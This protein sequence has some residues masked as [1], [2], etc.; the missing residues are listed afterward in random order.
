LSGKSGSDGDGGRL[1]FAPG[2]RRWLLEAECDGC[3]GYVLDLRVSD[4]EGR[5]AAEARA[6]AYLRNVHEPACPGCRSQER[7]RGGSS[8]QNGVEV[9]WDAPLGEWLGS[10]PLPGTG[11]AAWVPLG[12][13]TYWARRE[14]EAAA[15]MLL[16]SGVPLRVAAHRSEVDPDAFTVLYDPESGRWVLRAGCHRCGGFELRLL[17]AGRGAIEWACSQARRCVE[18]IGRDG[19]PHCRSLRERS[20]HRGPQERSTLWYDTSLGEWVA[21]QSIAGGGVT[22]PIGVARYDA[23]ERQLLQAGAAILFEDGGP[24]PEDELL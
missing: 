7:R 24:G 12:V 21:W 9:W 22:L 15:A 10:A 4:P 18:R 14:A 13:R 3:A 23:D 16:E 17:A 8:H 6:Q 19:C 11:H 20:V 1:Y 2:E 5:L